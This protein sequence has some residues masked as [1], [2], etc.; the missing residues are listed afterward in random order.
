M[1]NTTD[2]RRIARRHVLAGSGVLL[3]ALVLSAT[4]FAWNTAARTNSLTFR[5]AVALPG[6]T[7][8]AGTYLFEVV[9]DH[10]DIVRVLSTNRRTVHYTGFTRVIERPARMSVSEAVTFGEAARGMPHPIRAWYPIGLPE[11]RAFIYR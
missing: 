3:F 1:M 11:G 10:T 2:R 4:S 7:L 5:S 8:P 9:P 6:V